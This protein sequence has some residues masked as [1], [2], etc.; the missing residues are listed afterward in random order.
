MAVLELPIYIR[1]DGQ[2]TFQMDVPFDWTAGQVLKKAI[3]VRELVGS[4]ELR[5]RGDTL[6][7]ETALSDSGICAESQLDLIGHHWDIASLEEK[8]PIFKVTFENDRFEREYG[9]KKLDIF[10]QYVRGQDI[11]DN[12]AIFF[13]GASNDGRKMIEFRMLAT[14]AREDDYFRFRFGQVPPK[15][16][17]PV[18]LRL[19]K[20]V[21]SPSQMEMLY[22]SELR[23][24][25]G[26][27]DELY[28]PFFDA[29]SNEVSLLFH[30][31]LKCSIS[32]EGDVC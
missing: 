27:P 29:Q 7:E 2:E 25:W 4:W 19:L 12:H 15:D 1:Q 9:V 30:Q 22:L 18:P 5:F 21:L 23:R 14:S 26:I 13:R 8:Q 10:L 32:R 28:F 31:P 17:L 20:D 3:V 11:D 6:S 24:S 16:A